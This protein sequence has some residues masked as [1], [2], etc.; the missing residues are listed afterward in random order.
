MKKTLRIHALLLGAALLLTGCGGAT[1]QIA[2]KPVVAVGIVPVKTFVEAVC[3]DLCEVVTMIPPGASP[4]T[5]EPSPREQLKLS[6]ADAYFSVGMPAEE[7]SILPA[8]SEDTCAVRLDEAV[9]RQYDDL[10][11]GDARDPHIWLSTRRAGAMVEEICQTLSGQ[12]PQFAQTFRENADAYLSEL[13][14]TDAAVRAALSALENRAFIVFH[15]AFGYFADEYGLTMYAL[16]DEGKEATPRR[17]MEMVDF[18]RESGIRVIFYQAETDVS[19]AQA[20]A[21]EI[22]GTCVALDP[23]AAEYT[24]NLETMA[25]QIAEAAR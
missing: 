23:L 24:E 19:Q 22:G 25:A 17:L 6:E 9:R 1:E 13:N 18:A 21:E 8:L 15:P 7:N 14:R 4:E 20:F 16:E 12:Y 3:G 2:E 10:T 11:L 5:Y